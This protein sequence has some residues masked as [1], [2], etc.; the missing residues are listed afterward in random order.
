MWRQ[1]C[2]GVLLV[3]AC[4]HEPR[5]QAVKQVV[6]DD[7]Q[8]AEVS[9]ENWFV[10]RRPENAMQV[11]ARPGG[12]RAVQL[13]AH[14]V[15]PRILRLEEFLALERHGGCIDGD[16]KYR[17]DGTQR[18]ELWEKRELV[19]P[20][21]T[22]TWIQF[23]FMVASPPPGA[24]VPHLVI[25]QLKQDG[26]RSPVLAQR[27]SRRQFMV[28]INQDNDSPGRN[29]K[30]TDCRIIVAHDASL[31]TPFASSVGQ[32]AR[33]VVH[34]PPI[35]PGAPNS[36]CRLGVTVDSRE[37]LPSPFDQWVR[38]TYRIKPGIND[39]LLEVWADGTLVAKAAGRIGYRDNVAG[40]Q[41][42]KFGPYASPS[43]SHDV[44]AYLAR[45][46]R[47]PTCAGLGD[48]SAPECR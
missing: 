12:G 44:K 43:L 3:L 4:L 39:G 18:A 17:P 42:F 19:E 33:E 10:C 30:D 45:Y 21:G 13:L 38:M 8:G 31:R 1:W 40:S 5:A 29:P 2:C 36:G 35:G 25:G 34:A 15:R 26:D 9:P 16:G 7:F 27:F 46:R 24:A 22:E 28:T 47:A 11:V 14:R 32:D 48:P 6:H 20:F 37:L 41:Y 23:E